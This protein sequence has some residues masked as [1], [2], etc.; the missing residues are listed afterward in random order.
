MNEGREKAFRAVSDVL[1]LKL[2]I[3]SNLG[4]S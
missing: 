2:D 1:V 3:L 4:S